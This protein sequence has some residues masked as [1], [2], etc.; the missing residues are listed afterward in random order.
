MPTP[1][2]YNN[3]AYDDDDD[4]TVEGRIPT[5]QLRVSSSSTS[6]NAKKSRSKQRHHLDRTTPMVGGALLTAPE[7][8]QP[9]D[10]SS[11]DSYRPI[12][13]QTASDPTL[14]RGK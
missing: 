14:L 2:D 5:P 8:P 6:V 3:A 9:D 10:E 1:A 12:A 4:D 11:V 7:A 13:G